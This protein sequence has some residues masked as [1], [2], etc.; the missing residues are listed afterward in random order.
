MTIFE[1]TF[2]FHRGAFPFVF[3]FKQDSSSKETIYPFKWESQ[4][5]GSSKTIS[6]EV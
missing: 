6:D 3:L 2:F 4:G 1:E 5:I